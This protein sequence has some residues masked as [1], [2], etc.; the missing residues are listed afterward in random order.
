MP[1]PSQVAITGIGM[2]NSL[3][4]NTPECWGNMLQGKSGITRITRFD[5]SKCATKI[6]GE[7][8]AKYYEMEGVEFPKRLF[9]QTLSTTRLGFICAKQ[10]LSDSGFTLDGVDPY[11]VAVISGSGQSDFQEGQDYL[12][13]GDPGKYIIIKQMANAISA[14]ISIKNNFRGP[15]YNIATACA[16]GAFAVAAAFDYV[17]YGK[18]DAAVALGVDMMLT[19]ESIY[20]FNQLVAISERN[21]SPETACC[22]FDARRSGFVLANGGCALV[23]E[24]LEHAKK[25]NARIYAVV[26]G[27]GIC[28]ESYNIVAPDPSGEGMAKCM[29][30]ALA[31]GGV[32]PEKIGYISAHGTSTQHNDLIE[33]KAVKL[34]FKDHAR[35]LAVSSQK[36]MTGHTI[37]GAG[38]IECGVTALSLYHGKMTPTINQLE[39]D[40]ECDLDYVPNKSRDAQ[41]LAAALSN[42][43][44]FGGHNCSIL[45]EKYS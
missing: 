15:S 1:S 30:L 45:M 9:N 8:P 14:W 26:S 6:G 4:I 41:G 28:S 7:L 10:A 43:F 33:T 27:A 24:N 11:R 5:V 35:K 23:M 37:G 42:S 38:A 20:G 44:G 17:R 16:S 39:P 25:R 3:G 2:V 18:G 12:A 34:L 40:P 32:A 19:T 22:P 21:D 29:A 36:S 13:G 31:D